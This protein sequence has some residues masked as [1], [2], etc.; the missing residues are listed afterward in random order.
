[1]LATRKE[2]KHPPRLHK[3]PHAA[4]DDALSE[5]LRSLESGLFEPAPSGLPLWPLSEGD[6]LNVGKTSLQ[7][8]HTPGH[9]A[10]HI[11]LIHEEESVLLTG[12]HVLGQG[13]S[14]FEDLTAYL[15]SLRKCLRLLTSGKTRDTKWTLFPAHGPVLQEGAVSLQ[16]YLDHRLEREDQIVKLLA[17]HHEDQAHWTIPALV[18][19][20]YSNY[21]ESLYPAAARGLFL[22]LRKLA[23]PDPEAIERGVVED[24]DKLRGRRVNCSGDGAGSDGL[25]PSVPNGD[26]AWLR[27]MELRWSLLPSVQVT[28]SKGAL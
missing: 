15:V 13:T 8:V 11:C 22:H 18:S 14:V 27:A 7:V 25:A 9:T 26:A 19:N 2:Q 28:L 21:P 3:Y 17:S 10:D 12:D 24:N 4:S 20:L 5:R 23:Q 16:Q 1:M 6:K